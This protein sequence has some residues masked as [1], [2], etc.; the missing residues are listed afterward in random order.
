MIG[1]SKKEELE[2]IEKGMQSK[3]KEI[4]DEIK[5]REK[6]EQINNIQILYRKL[7]RFAD[8]NNKEFKDDRFYISA[9]GKC[10]SIRTESHYYKTPGIVYFSSLKLAEEA[11]EI[12]KDELEK[13]Y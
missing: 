6:E 12:F 10:F 9:W 2:I 1:M 5:I 4:Q 7:Q 13:C 3:L 8:E 11:I